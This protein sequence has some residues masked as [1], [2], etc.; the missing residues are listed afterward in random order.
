[1]E[2]EFSPQDVVRGRCDYVLEDFRRDLA[3]ELRINLP[4]NSVAESEQ[5]FRLAYDLCYWMATER[6]FA[7]FLD[8]LA[9]D[10]D[11]IRLAH[12]LREPM[13]P[14]VEM[15]GAILQR[16]IND[17]IAGGMDVDG[18][19]ERVALAHAAICGNSPGAGHLA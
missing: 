3:T 8:D 14:N 11:A 13:R 5:D 15:L 12:A 10:P 2:W 1:M 19:V 9:D 6:P 18:A 4:R 16:M 17:A 7:R